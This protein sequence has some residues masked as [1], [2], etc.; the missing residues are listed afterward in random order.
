[1][2]LAH[3]NFFCPTNNNVRPS[4]IRKSRKTSQHKKSRSINKRRKPEVF[5]EDKNRARR[6]MTG[7]PSMPKNAHVKNL[8]L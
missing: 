7:N 3:Y 4:S 5:F 1:M 2:A 6:L 8:P